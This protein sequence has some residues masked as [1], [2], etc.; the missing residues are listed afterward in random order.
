MRDSLT[1]CL[2]TDDVTIANVPLVG[3]VSKFTSLN[4][5]RLLKVGYFISSVGFFHV[6]LFLEFEH[7]CKYRVAQRETRSSFLQ[8]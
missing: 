1:G 4:Q 8:S 2:S 6:T 7:G 5:Q 3:L